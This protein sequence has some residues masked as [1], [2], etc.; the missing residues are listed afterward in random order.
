MLT[1]SRSAGEPREWADPPH[2]GDAGG[3]EPADPFQLRARPK[4]LRHG[5]RDPA[6]AVVAVVTGS[7]CVPSSAA[8][9]DS[10]IL[11]SPSRPRGLHRLSAVASLRICNACADGATHISGPWTIAYAPRRRGRVRPFT[12]GAVR[13]SRTTR[14][15]SEQEATARTRLIAALA[16]NRGESPQPARGLLRLARRRP[17]YGR[18]REHRR[19]DSICASSRLRRRRSDERRGDSPTSAIRLEEVP[20]PS[21]PSP[22]VACVSG[23]IPATVAGRPAR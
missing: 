18:S 22:T 17:A 1:V 8:R 7:W 12:G 6:R 21:S 13:P 16:R 19:A 15:E 11:A 10:R 5:A 3:R 20:T 4:R 14:H 2:E 23:S 9:S